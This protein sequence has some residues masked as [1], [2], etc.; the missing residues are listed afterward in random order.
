MSPEVKASVFEPFYT[1]KPLGDGTG[2]GLSMIYGIARQPG[3]QVKI[4][5]ELGQGTTMCIYL[6]RHSD[7]AMIDEVVMLPIPPEPSGGCKVVLV[8]DDDPTIRMLVAEVLAE[9]GYAVIEAPDGPAGLRVLE[10]CARVDL[11]ITDV[12]LESSVCRRENANSRCVSVE[13]RLTAPCAARIYLSISAARPC[14]TRIWIIS[15]LPLL[16]V[17]R[18]LKSCASP[19]G[20][21]ANCFHL[22]RLAQ[23]LLDRALSL[24]S[25]VTFASQS[26][27]RPRSGSYRRS[28]LPK[29]GSR[30]FGHASLRS[31]TDLH[32]S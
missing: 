5:S 24:R 11:L 22:L 32:A 16:P 26:A 10:S 29:S 30:P 27:R 14:A 21:L 28:H 25:R 31:R 1:T 8:I 18:L 7:D 13:A 9:A 3:G 15:R 2:L 12:G 4:Y 23:L 6:P 19:P 20:Q 17:K